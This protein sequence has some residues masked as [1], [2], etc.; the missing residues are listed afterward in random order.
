MYSV[1][2]GMFVFLTGYYFEGRTNSYRSLWELYEKTGSE[3]KVQRVDQVTFLSSAQIAAIFLD[4]VVATIFFLL[5][6]IFADN[7]LRCYSDC[8]IHFSRSAMLH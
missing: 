8:P 1:T 6:T 4:T 5:V 7:S 2:S 3:G